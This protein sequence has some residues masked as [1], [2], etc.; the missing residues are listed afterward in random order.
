MEAILWPLMSEYI[1]CN[2]IMMA[3]QPLFVAKKSEAA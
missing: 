2:I 3:D 1:E